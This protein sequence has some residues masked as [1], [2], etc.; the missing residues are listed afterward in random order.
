MSQ[1]LCFFVFGFVSC[2]FSFLFVNWWWPVPHFLSVT[3]FTIDIDKNHRI[4]PNLYHNSQTS[5]LFYKANNVCNDYNGYILC[6]YG[7]SNTRLKFKKIPHIYFLESHGKQAKR[8]KKH[9]KTKSHKINVN[10][11]NC[12]ISK[13]SK[14]CIAGI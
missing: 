9:M 12:Q 2:S 10:I 3:T 8:S 13:M 5:H 1:C 14:S 7:L 11:I 6:A 4:N